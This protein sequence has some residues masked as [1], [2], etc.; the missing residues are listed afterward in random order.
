MKQHIGQIT[1]LDFTRLYRAIVAGIRAVISN[2]EHLNKINVFPVADGDTGTNMAL[3]LNAILD[4]TYNRHH[5][6]IHEFLDCVSECALNG[7]R[8]N[9]GTILAQ[10]FLGFSEAAAKVNQRFTTK[11][12]VAAICHAS[13]MAHKALSEPK[14]GTILTVMR[15]FSDEMT[16]QLMSHEQH[17][18]TSLL[19]TSLIKSKASLSNT[20]SQ[21]IELKKAGVVDAGAQG[22]VDFLQGIY[23]FIET[24]SVNELHEPI[25]T[26]EHASPEPIH[27]NINEKF[28]YCTECI[29]KGQQLDLNSLRHDLNEQG[30]CVIVA[31]SSK[32]AKIHI[33][34]NEP[35]T[36]FDIAQRYGH[37][38]RE[39]ADDMLQQQ[40]TIMH[41]DQKV[42]ILTD[43]SADFSDNETAELNIHV[44]PLSLTLDGK[45]YLDK[46]SITAK[47][48]YEKLT[49][50][51]S[52]PTTSQPSMGDLKR[53]YQFLST[54][55]QSIIA[56]HLPEAISGTLN[57]SKMAA[58]SVS[59]NITVTDGLTVSAGLGL[60]I[61]AAARA[62][63]AGHTH[64]KILNIIDDAIA[65]TYNFVIVND[66][67]FAI[68]GG[69]ISKK[70]KWILEA[71]RITPILSFNKQ[72]KAVL[73][74]ITKAKK[75]PVQKA[76]KHL[77]RHLSPSKRY[78]IQIMHTNVQQQ[79]DELKE[80]IEANYPDLISLDS[81]I[82]TAVIGAH[83]GPGSLGVAFQENIEI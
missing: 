70:K 21:L 28:R 62:A 61:N 39:K 43:S 2:Q 31:G 17:D 48:F 72:G 25:S 71:L 27:N 26:A 67:S 35:Q 45:H 47:E 55:Y 77:K 32:L 82:C 23:D 9:S 79:A 30:N 76:L 16:Q 14:E 7:A 78:R 8:G 15:D 83:I 37:P 44:V 60:I 51:K 74:G 19:H 18:F 64:D 10:F 58:K 6:T 4:G 66:L 81:I 22:F 34:T 41:I 5:K 69:R 52:F 54:H 38:S 68:K 3:T 24:G 49:Q 63:A 29:I 40:H 59:D 73:V 42:A 12:F 13:N 1:Y 11:N 36:V 46:L 75:N 33:H 50:I 57:A 80:L 20:T 53:Q 65:K 56:I